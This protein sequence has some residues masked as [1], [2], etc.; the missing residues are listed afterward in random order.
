MLEKDLDLL[1]VGVIGQLGDALH[2][3]PPGFRIRTLESVI[4]A[5]GAGPDDK[6]GP[7]LT[8][9]VY[10]APQGIYALAAERFVGVY[11]SAERVGR[12]GVEAC[13]D[14]GQVHP[15]GGEDP[16]HLLGVVLV[17]LTR[18]VVLEPFQDVVEPTGDALRLL[19]HRLASDLAV[20]AR[21]HEAGHS[22][23]ECPYPNRVLDHRASPLFSLQ[24]GALAPRSIIV[25]TVPR[26]RPTMVGFV[27]GYECSMS[28]VTALREGVGLIPVGILGARRQTTVEL[29]LENKSF[30]VGGAS[31]GLGRAVAEQ[32]VEEGA[33][34]L[35][36]A[37][38]G[39][40]I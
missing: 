24:S 2:K 21:R 26:A 27:Q 29:G 37:R 12:V 34:V 39:D 40:A 10:A 11:E 35:L 1:L 20:V 8:A 19:D 9:E 7:Y 14:H 30:V 3:T 5:L 36:V 6:V 18:I 15:V 33:R 22:R 31:S 16:Q 23:T 28:T 17:D 25:R 38:S 32:L 4:I 13:G